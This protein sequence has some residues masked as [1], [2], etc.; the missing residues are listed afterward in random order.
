MIRVTKKAWFG[1]KKYLG[2]GWSPR[3]WQ[4]WAVT[5]VTVVLLIASLTFLG[6]PT[7]YI[8]FA[9]IIVA[10]LLVMLFTGDLPGGPSS[11]DR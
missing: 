4:G 6:N 11:E 3:T 9:V 8:A 1:P 10:H 2:W 7:R 5:A